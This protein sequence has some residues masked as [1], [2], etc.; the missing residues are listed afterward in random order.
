[1]SLTREG[2]VAVSMSLTREGAW[3][4]ACRWQ[5]KGVSLEMD[6]GVTVNMLEMEGGMAVNMSL[7]IEGG[8]A[9]NMLAREKRLLS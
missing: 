9:V 4:S 8:V 6:G 5:G 2:S 3:L 1:M 7:E